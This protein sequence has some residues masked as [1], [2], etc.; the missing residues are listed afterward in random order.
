MSTYNDGARLY[1]SI[2]SILSQSFTDFEFLIV[3]DCSAQETRSILAS[4]QK[5]D[6]RIRVIENNENIGF[7][8]SLN[9]GVELSQGKYIA[10]M[11]ADDC[12]LPSRLEVENN[13]LD[14]HPGISFCGSD[15]G[16][17]DDEGVW[18]TSALITCPTRQ[19]VCLSNRFS[20][21]TILLRKE[22]LV[23]VHG[24]TVF[25]KKIRVSEDYDLWCKLY[26]HNLCGYNIQEILLLYRDDF[27]SAKRRKFKYQILLVKL[28]KQWC[29][30]FGVSKA[31][32]VRHALLSLLPFLLPKRLYI[33]LRKKKYKKRTDSAVIRSLDVALEAQKERS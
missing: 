1:L 21:P 33:R 29:K 3:D 16:F 14:S 20:H 27:D 15:F 24:Y 10:R 19:Q 13:F 28:K 26:L 25:P 30:E 17:F 7:C 6:S 32:F 2:G 5:K 31:L 8:R 23:S 9:K 4:F 12:S 11:D 18:G 22:D